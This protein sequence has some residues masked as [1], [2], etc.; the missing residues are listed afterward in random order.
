MIVAAIASG[1]VLERHRR[2]GEI[3]TLRTAL[4]LSRMSADSCRLALEWEQE[5]FLRFNGVVDSLRSEVDGYEDPARGGVPE[6][7]YSDYLVA[8]DLYNDSVEVWQDRADSLQAKES[9]CRELVESHNQL[10]D[11]I[12][13][14]QE[15][16]RGGGG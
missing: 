1:P 3:Q 4:D 10:S 7:V 11:S 14:V 9:R 8:F 16:G 12:R 6:E 15:G 13:N 5:E 2:A